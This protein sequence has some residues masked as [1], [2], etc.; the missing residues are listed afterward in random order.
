M[1]D[2]GWSRLV[3]L[4][5]SGGFSPGGMRPPLLF[6]LEMLFQD[7]SAHVAAAPP[8]LYA[9]AI[10]RGSEPMVRRRPMH[11]TWNCNRLMNVLKSVPRLSGAM[12]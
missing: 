2:D 1:I 12:A 5:P 8:F 9:P 6:G 4:L 11:A 3:E 10:I 7:E